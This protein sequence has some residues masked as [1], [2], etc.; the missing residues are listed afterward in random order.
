MGASMS[1]NESLDSMDIT[2][3]RLGQGLEL[4]LD[5]LAAWML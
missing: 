3:E 5:R 4:A 1:Q 2:E